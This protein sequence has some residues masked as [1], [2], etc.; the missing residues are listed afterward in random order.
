M[1]TFWHH[2]PQ[3]LLPVSFG[4]VARELSPRTRYHKKRWRAVLNTIANSLK[5]KQRRAPLFSFSLP[6][7]LKPPSCLAAKDNHYHICWIHPA[8]LEK[9]FWVS[10]HKSEQ[11]AAA[12]LVGGKKT[13]TIK[14][15]QV[16]F[17]HRH[18]FIGIHTSHYTLMITRQ[19][20]TLMLLYVGTQNDVTVTACEKEEKKRH[21]PQGCMS[22]SVVLILRQYR[23]GRLK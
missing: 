13:T 12:R 14:P 20:H 6:P 1:I 8:L 4:A 5:G 2:P 16:M 15:R 19:H 17:I 3:H 7:P 11:R 9:L 18:L 10:S 22:T 21:S 23:G